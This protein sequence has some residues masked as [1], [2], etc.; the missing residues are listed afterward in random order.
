M[1]FIPVEAMKKVLVSVFLVFIVCALNAQMSDAINKND[2]GKVQTLA[3]KDSTLLNRVDKNGSTPLYVAALGNNFEMVKLLV[4]LGAR[5]NARNNDGS[6]ALHGAAGSGNVS[7]IGYLLD[8]GAN[9]EAHDNSFGTTPLV[10]AIMSNRPEALK[11]FIKNGADINAYSSIGSLPLFYA[12]I[13]KNKELI[14]ILLDAGAD[15][16]KI[17]AKGLTPLTAASALGNQEIIKIFND[18]GK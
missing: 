10:M 13:G 12:I 9:I 7:I 5:V 3:Q 16:N 2:A 6:T 18:R 1:N 14:K 11:F 15:V 4:S 17:M 8:H